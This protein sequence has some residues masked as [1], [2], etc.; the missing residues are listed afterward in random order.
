M[1]DE[2]WNLSKS[3]IVT[4]ELLKIQAFWDMM[5]R[6]IK[7]SISQDRTI[8]ISRAKPSQKRVDFMTLKMVSQP[9][10]MSVTVT[11]LRNIPE[12]LVY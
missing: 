6:L 12:D 4:P 3:E 5:Y 7:S 8:F 2:E 9:Y 11:N 1:L 10:K